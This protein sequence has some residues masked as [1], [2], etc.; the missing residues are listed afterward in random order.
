M[1]FTPI[2]NAII[3]LLGAIIT[4]VLI[5]WIRKKTTAEQA[6]KINKLVAIAVQA[7]EQLAEPGMGKEKKQF[8]LDFLQSKGINI[9]DEA[10]DLAIE[11]AVYQ[12]KNG[13]L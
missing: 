11:A 12:L 9:D 6:E 7:A 10:I 2:F 4:A 1:D 3:A 8:V 5:P 13:L